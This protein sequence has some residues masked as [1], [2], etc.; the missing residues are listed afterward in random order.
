V[1]RR[2][3]LKAIGIAAL[4]PILLRR[5]LATATPGFRRV[6]PSD[7]AWP[8]KSAWQQLND[9]VGG[10][11]VPVDF[12]LSILKSDPN[13]AA[14]KELLAN[15]KN[16][17]FIREHAG[18]TQSLGWIDA[19]KTSPSLYAVMARNANDIAAAVNFAREHQLRLVVRGGGHSYQ[20][21]SNAP[22]SLLVWTESGKENEYLPSRLMWSNTRGEMRARSNFSR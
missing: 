22:D 8:S 15:L 20:G 7:A 4:P 1:T 9:A 6:R 19:W 13:G 12:P 11:L 10:N 2:A 14:A 17:Y 16:P 21:T 18:L 3:F 5:A